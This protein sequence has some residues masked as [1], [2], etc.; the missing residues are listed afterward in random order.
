VDRL[1]IVGGGARSGFWAQLMADALGVE[2]VRHADADAGGALGAARL[3]RMAAGAGVDESCPPP[4]ITDRCTPAPA[5][6]DVLARRLA[7][8]RALYAP[9]RALPPIRP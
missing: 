7:V 5:R 2:I 3:G 8:F 4:P 9:L 1:S 6:Q